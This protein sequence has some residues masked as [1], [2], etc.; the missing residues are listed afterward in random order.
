MTYLFR[1]FVLPLILYHVVVVS[2]PYHRLQVVVCNV[3]LDDALVA[4]DTA[5]TCNLG[6]GKA[7]LHKLIEDLFLFPARE[8]FCLIVCGHNLSETASAVDS[9]FD[10]I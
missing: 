3:L 5:C 2:W 4:V 8:G 9:D 6:N 10:A 1:A 7:C